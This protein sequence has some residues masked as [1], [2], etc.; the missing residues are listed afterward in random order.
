MHLTAAPFLEINWNLRSKNIGRY[1]KIYD[2]VSLPSDWC[3]ASPQVPDV[4]QNRS[5]LSCTSAPVQWWRNNETVRSQPERND[6][7]AHYACCGR[8]QKCNQDKWNAA[9]FVIRLPTVLFSSRF[10][11]FLFQLRA[12]ILLP[13]AIARLNIC[14]T[15]CSLAQNVLHIV[16]TVLLLKREHL[17]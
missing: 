12:V 1:S 10:C 17:Y 7:V 4:Q 6:I 8:A 13:S 2:L 11:T 5:Q 14:T 15:Y 9:D 16:C 3:P